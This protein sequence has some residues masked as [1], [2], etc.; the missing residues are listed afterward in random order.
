VEFPIPGS[1][2][3]SSF[4]RLSRRKALALPV[5]NTAIFVR[6]DEGLKVFEE[7]RM[8]IGPVSPIPFRPREAEALL[9]NS[10]VTKEMIQKAGE[11]ASEEASPRTSLRGGK[12]YR[13]EMVKVLV[14]RGLRQALVR[15]NSN[16]SIEEEEA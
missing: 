14:V 11:V 13:K 9:K 6:L 3:G 4:Q 15:V 5:L 16:L 8:V 1:R 10:P 2:S 7:I 12:E